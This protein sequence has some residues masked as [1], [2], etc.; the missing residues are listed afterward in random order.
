MSQESKGLNQM[1][2]DVTGAFSTHHRFRTQAGE[3]GELVFPAFSQQATF[4]GAGGRELSMHK[5]G[6]LSSSHECLAGNQVR[7]VAERRGLFSRGIVIQFDGQDYALDPEG[8]LSRTWYLDDAQGTRLLE[9]R[10]RG[11][12]RQ[13]AYLAFEPDINSDLIVFAYYLVYVQQQEDA[14]AVAAT[15][16]ATAS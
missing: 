12:F 15:G 11:I 13:G 2:V 16:A 14:A 7:G 9:I 4:R 5:K 1:E 8:V 6:L 10:P 3:E